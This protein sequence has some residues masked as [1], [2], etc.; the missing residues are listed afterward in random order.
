MAKYGNILAIFDSGP[1]TIGDVT[2]ILKK[3]NVLFE[4]IDNQFYIETTSKKNTNNIIDD[5]N[6]LDILFLFF[7]NN[8]SDGSLIRSKGIDDDT[9]DAIQKILF[10]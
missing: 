1:Q 9:I 6:G 8:I 3:Y 2:T 7:H 4:N 5:L 10:E